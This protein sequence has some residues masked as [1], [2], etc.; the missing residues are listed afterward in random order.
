M[1]T[2]AAA[3][4]VRRDRGKSWYL[5]PWLID[6]GSPAA[7]AE[8]LAPG[9]RGIPFNELRPHHLAN[10]ARFAIAGRVVLVS[11][12]KSRLLKRSFMDN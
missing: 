7:R 10:Q 9:A 12:T 5:T 8:N 3:F 6:V 11:G 2:T 1:T 4:A